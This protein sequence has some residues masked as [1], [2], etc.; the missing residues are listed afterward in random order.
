M[1]HPLRLFR[2]AA[3]LGALTAFAQPPARAGDGSVQLE[4]EA[5]PPGDGEPGNRP[6]W[7]DPNAAPPQP[8]IENDPTPFD[9]A[10]VGTNADTLNNNINPLDPN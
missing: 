8:G 5:A 2:L 7:A 4:R 1:P 3:F 10:D 9:P 6:R